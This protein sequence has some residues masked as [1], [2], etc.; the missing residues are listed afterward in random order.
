MLNIPVNTLY[1]V[2]AGAVGA[3]TIAAVGS[4]CFGSLEEAY[5]A[6]KPEIIARKPDPSVSAF[7]E[8]MIR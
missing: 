2:S 5:R 3:A 8:T 6:R 7:Y 1:G 4:S